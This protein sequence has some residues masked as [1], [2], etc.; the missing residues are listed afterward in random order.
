MQL[1]AALRQGALPPGTLMPVLRRPAEASCLGFWG[2][3]GGFVQFFG[4]RF[5][6]VSSLGSP[7]ASRSVLVRLSCETSE[8]LVLPCWLCITYSAALRAVPKV[9]RFPNGFLTSAPT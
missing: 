2:G 1:R 3:G 6:G 5:L 7:P 9:G 4:D 8:H